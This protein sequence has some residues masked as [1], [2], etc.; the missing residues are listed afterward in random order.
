ML[1]HAPVSGRSAR[2]LRALR[3][4]GAGLVLALAAFSSV[5]AQEGE[6]DLF[7]IRS[8]WDGVY[9]EEQA[10]EGLEVFT[11]ICANCHNAQNPLG[12]D[13]FLR[14][15]SGK[16]LHAVWEFMTTRM[17][18]GAPG[19]LTPQQYSAVLAYVLKSNGYPAGDRPIPEMAHEVAN[20]DFDPPRNP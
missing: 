12:G 3:P 6:D 15:W 9:T 1:R 5:A 13:A 14:R 10:A 11:N 2:V 16:P 20:I 19:S 17:P 4:A 8:T 18:Y 7:A